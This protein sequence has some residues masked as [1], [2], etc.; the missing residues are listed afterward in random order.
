MQEIF[1]NSFTLWRQFESNIF[2][3]LIKHIKANEVYLVFLY[4]F[5]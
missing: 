1:S 2:I 3:N 4:V 5:Y